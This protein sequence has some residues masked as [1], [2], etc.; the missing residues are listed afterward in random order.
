MAA[1][2]KTV[3]QPS[4]VS[5]TLGQEP[6]WFKDA[7]IYQLHVRAF[8]DG[9]GDGIGDFVGLTQKLDYIQGL[10][11]TA[12]WLLPFF[13][14]PLRDD[15]YDIADY[16]AIN[17]SYGTLRDFQKF[18]DE[19][20][21]RDLRVITEM[22]M[23]HTSD[24]HEWFQK[25]RRAKKG[26]RWR[27]F[28]VWSDSDDR[29]Q[30]ARIIFQDF[31]TSN[32]TWDPVAEA[33]F[34]HRFY[35]HQPDLNF[36]NPDVHE[37]M[38]DA[39]DFWMDM[40]I[41][42]VR[43]D[44]VPYLYQR[45]GTNCENLPETHAFL[46]KLREHVDSKYP[47]R[48]LLAEANQWP[49]D[50]AAYFGDGDECHM[51]FH[52]P[53]MPRL[54][55]AIE[56]E[57]RFPI[58]DILEQ[59][60]P[61]P[62]N[63]QWGIFL[64]NHDE[65]TL[66]MVTDEERDYMY[67]AF[68][69]DP[70]ARVNLG[71]RRRLAPLLRDNRRKMELMNALLLSLPGTPIIYYGDEICM[72]DNIYLG[73][74]D[75]VRT[76]MQWSDDRNAGFSRV[77]PQRLYLPV[78]IDAPYHYASRNVEVEQSRPHSMLWWTRRII[79]LRKMCPAFGRGTIEFVASENPK[80][81]AFLRIHEEETILVVAN[82]SRYAQCAELDLSRFRG[83]T[84]RELFGQTQ[85]PPIGELPYF[86]TLGPFTFY[87]FRL[88]REA[89]ETDASQAELPSIRLAGTTGNWDRLFE[90]RERGKLEAAVPGFLRR[91]RWFAGKARSIQ[92]ITL[93][94]VLTLQDVPR[95]T[96]EVRR[97]GRSATDPLAPTRILI[98]QVEYVE[99]EPERYALPLLFAQGEQARNIVGDHPS[100]A[101]ARIERAPD[102]E[103]AV[104][105]ETTRESD[106]W[107]LLFDLI[108]RRRAISGTKGEVTSSQTTALNRIGKE[109]L[110][111]ASIH[112][113]EQSNTSAVLGGKYILK[114][115][116]RL[117]AGIN[118][119]LEVGRYL[120]EQSPISC[121]PKVA[122][123]LEY[124]DSQGEKYTLGVLHEYIPNE[125]DAWV[126]TLDELGRY[127]ERV[128]SEMTRFPASSLLARG[129]SWRSLINH[130][131]PDAAR[132][133]MGPYVQAATLLGERTA[134]LHRALGAAKGEG[135]EREAFSPEAFTK[136]YQRSLYQSMRTPAKRIFS[137][138]RKKHK[139]LSGQA[140]DLAEQVLQQ[141]DAVMQRFGQLIERPIQALRIRCHGDYHLGQVLFTGKDFV[142]IDFEG[143]PD[144][145]VG[146][147]RIKSS[148]LRDVAGMIRSFHYASHAA[149][150]G[151]IHDQGLLGEM[152]DREERILAWLQVWYTWS[153]ACFLQSYLTGMRE[154][155]L[156]PEGEDLELL[157]HS[158]LL[159]KSIYELGYELNNRPDWVHIPLLGILQSLES[160]S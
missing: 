128:E 87:W 146:E 121:V 64:R 138:L 69:D 77:N 33:Y 20:H 34:W 139:D 38:F 40:G 5:S 141:E 18:L 101:V 55:M 144:R 157:L 2:K 11:V 61:I 74:R 79:A 130:S 85:F 126:Y 156:L 132:D 60:P 102:G 7:V 93:Q 73:D 119:D 44:A 127:I 158:Y 30:E 42:G 28:Y 81:L 109:I 106:F 150:R 78:I 17:P 96:R 147:R 68:A 39:I 16:T 152:I 136:L 149:L 80:V 135:K 84:P 97:S 153:T 142:I 105:C 110:L 154:V 92:R 113:G 145:T 114:L 47:H 26:D 140:A 24:Q 58:I 13:P 160:S 23:N 56:R 52:F 99:G 71:I 124:C 82:L 37:A 19:A 15:G 148:P 123:A 117:G 6:L 36:D 67:R 94:D 100:A 1:K 133:L 151:P 63:C 76:P 131:L 70:R 88:E 54:F 14:S 8:H 32:W 122:G 83:Q 27:D 104:L 22:V 10:G 98:L 116:R 66:E 49:E 75:G 134:E 115:F 50:A 57:D 43:L 25:S 155:D 48:M 65:L 31:E 91:Q 46:K 112:S 3:R 53:L 51:N 4:R 108:V 72:G 86:L 118:P 62:E 21:R 89:A 12:I 129:A 107:L 90:S 159:D 9:N 59:T 41:D 137:L 35:H 103:P 95:I 45:D 143:E 29:Y 120:T 125:G 111:E